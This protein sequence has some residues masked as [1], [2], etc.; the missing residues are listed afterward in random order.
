MNSVRELLAQA[1]D[2]L[3]RQSEQPALDSEVLLAHALGR[4]RSWLYAWPEHVPEGDRLARFEYLVLQRQQGRPV[5]QLVGEREFW[6]LRLKVSHDTLIPRPETEHLVEIALGLKLSDNARVLDLGTGSGALAL[7]LASERPGWRIT[8][9]DQSQAALKVAQ[10]NAQSL[11]LGGV[12]F[13]HSDWFEA[14][15]SGAHYD[16]IVSNP[17]YVAEQDPHLARGD[18]RFEPPQALVSGADGLDDIRRIAAA[19]AGFL[20][21]GGW[22]WLEHG[23]EQGKPVTELLRNSGF[24]QVA[25][26]RDLAGHER[27]SGGRLPTERTVTKSG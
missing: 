24:V 2:R 18:L 7:A 12:S 8:A 23:A 26:R 3:A 16:L 17:P 14:L 6:S 25:V 9:L 13:L 19:A 21:P 15:P 4:D 11:N 20:R 22:L 5:A 1:R 27:H 10:E